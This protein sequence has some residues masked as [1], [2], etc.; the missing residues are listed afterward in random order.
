M[1]IAAHSSGRT[2]SVAVRTLLV[3]T[4]LLGVGY[5]A[6]V[7]GLGY[8]VFPAQSHGSLFENEQGEVRGSALIGQSFADADG[9]PLPQYFQPRPSAAGDHGYDA[10]SSAG[11]NWG[12]ENENLIE[13]ITQRKKAIAELNGVPE[14]EVPADALTASSS[15]LDPH[16][17]SRYA[18]IQVERVARER[19]LPVE[20]VRELV[21]QHTKKP[22]LGYVGDRVVNVAELNL[23]LDE[24]RR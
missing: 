5:T 21:S 15:G 11:T 16:I 12:P 19:G 1:S 24:T 10:A 9:N 7:T 6:L 17:S 22:D 13:S 4:V 8:V 23:A 2:M 20:Q 14:S 3:L 18:D